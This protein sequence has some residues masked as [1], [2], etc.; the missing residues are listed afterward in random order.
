MIEFEY[1]G[2]PAPQNFYPDCDTAWRPVIPVTLLL[3]N[4][5][6][7]TY[8]LLDSGAD[9]C[10]FRSDWGEQIG[11]HIKS[12]KSCYFSGIEGK[13]IVAYFHKIKL[14]L[15]D[16]MIISLNCGFSYD[17]AKRDMPY[18]ILGQYGFFNKFNIQFDHSNKKI[19]LDKPLSS[20]LHYKK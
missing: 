18:G 5:S 15:E 4:K 17:M 1:R 20:T 8:A 16:Q 11:L 14:R 12:G 13:P 6:F 2:F 7:T 9:Q 3:S 19:R 10:I